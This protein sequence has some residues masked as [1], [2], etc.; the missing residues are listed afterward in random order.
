MHIATVKTPFGMAD[1]ICSASFKSAA[2]VSAGDGSFG[3]RASGSSVT[4][5]E[6][7]AP[8]RFRYSSQASA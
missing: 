3:L 7:N 5:T 4:L 6:Q 8:S 2:A 1:K